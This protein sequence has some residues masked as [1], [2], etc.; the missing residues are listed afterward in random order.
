MLKH[1]GD[2]ADIESAIRAEPRGG[3]GSPSLGSMVEHLT[4]RPYVLLSWNW[5]NS[6]LAASAKRT[7][8]EG[9]GR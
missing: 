8:R 3:C 9:A 6:P 2:E 4:P 5:K 7:A 1:Y